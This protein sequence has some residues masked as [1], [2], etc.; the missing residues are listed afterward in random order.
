MQVIIRKANESDMKSV[1]SLI[2][3]LAIFEK[4]P[5]MVEV[6]EAQLIEDGFGEKP[7]FEALLAEVNG[8][9]VGMALYYERYSTWKGKTIH[10]EDLIVKETHRNQGLGT[11]LYN[12]VLKTAQSRGYKRVE[13][14][15]LDWNK[16]A[17]DFYESTGAKILESWRVVQ[18]DKAGLENYLNTL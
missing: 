17:I 12:E 10:L 7:A 4:E 1:L 2:N 3:D 11:K 6:T 5:H 13:W 14:N 18:M 8:Q 9:V 16:V 15:V